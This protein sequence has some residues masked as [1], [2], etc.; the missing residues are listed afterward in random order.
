MTSRLIAC[1][2]ALPLLVTPTAAGSTFRLELGPAVAANM[3]NMKKGTAFV[4][5][6]LACD[7][8]ALMRI[9]AVADA[10]VNGSR[11]SVAID[12]LPLAVAGAYAVPAVWRDAAPRVVSLTAWCGAETAGAVVPL[13]LAGFVRDTS[14]VFD[15]APARADVDAALAALATR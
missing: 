13:G 7:A 11:Q 1:A 15:R 10:V 3:P 6:G 5:R 9:A 8:P 2:L 12:L 14:R 4:V